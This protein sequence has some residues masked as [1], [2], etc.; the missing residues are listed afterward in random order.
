M[1]LSKGGVFSRLSLKNQNCYAPS[2]N[3]MN[4]Y[5]FFE[6]S[7]IAVTG[8]FSFLPLKKPLFYLRAPKFLAPRSHHRTCPPL[9]HWPPCRPSTIM[10]HHCT[11]GQA[12]IREALAI[13][14][15]SLSRANRATTPWPRLPEPCVTPDRGLPNARQQPD[16]ADLPAPKAAPRARVGRAP[17]PTSH[18]PAPPPFWPRSGPRAVP[19]S[20]Q[21]CSK[22]N[23]HIFLY[24]FYSYL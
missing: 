17:S 20:R 1:C 24:I 2:C 7:K 8:K 23:K 13:P 12:W 4:Y 3:I 11:H 21:F 22:V 6:K 16:R 14:Y 15:R 9:R 5:F 10:P 19:R 18:C